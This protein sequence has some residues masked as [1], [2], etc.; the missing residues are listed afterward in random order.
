MKK[1]IY[2]FTN[3]I[4][5]K[6]YIGQTKNIKKRIYQH[7]KGKTYKVSKIHNAIKKYGIEN[8]SIEILEHDIE[9]YNEREKYWIKFY[10]S[11][12]NGYNICPG[13]EEP[14]IIKGENSS[15]T[16]FTDQEIANIVIALKENILSYEEISNK[17][18]VSN[19]Y[20]QRINIGEVRKMENEKYPLRYQNNIVKSE[21]F[22]LKVINE[23]QNTLKPMTDI[24]KEYNTSRKTIWEIN[25]GIMKNS[26]KNIIYPIRSKNNLMSESILLDLIQDIK[27]KKLKF[28]EIEQKYHVS[29]AFINRVNNGKTYKQD[30]ETYP[31]RKSSERVY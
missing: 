13:G 21:E 19:A 7:I 4:N 31:L 22:I 27:N 20:L 6:I 10:N 26:P 2:K 12:E 9:N 3:K 29:K 25:N 18:N 16:K 5:G 14:P 1:D 23:L 30:N 8:F 11:I 24:V 28:S 15:L 17:Y